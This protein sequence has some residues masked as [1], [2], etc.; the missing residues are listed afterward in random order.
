VADI[1]VVGCSNRHESL[2]NGC[3]QLADTS[4][5]LFESVVVRKLTATYWVIWSTLTHYATGLI[6]YKFHSVPVDRH[7]NW[8]THIH[9]DWPVRL[10]TS[11]HYLYIRPTAL[12]RSGYFQPRQLHPVACSLTTEAAKTMIQAFICCRLD[13]NSLLY[14]ASDGLIQKLQSVQ[15]AATRLI[16]HHGRQIMW[17][18]LERASPVALASYPATSGVQSCMPGASV[19]VRSCTS[20]H[21]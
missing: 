11:H 7:N 10:R 13:Y 4:Q 8:H 16:S 15:N 17:P 9:R 18:H 19:V 1:A 2:G 3:Q 6:S 21:T 14:G 20:W 5:L 12:C